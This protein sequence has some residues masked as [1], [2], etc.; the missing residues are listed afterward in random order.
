MFKWID[1]L[2]FIVGAMFTGSFSRSAVNYQAGVRTAVSNIVMAIVVMVVLLAI[3]PLFHYTPNCI[4]SAIIISAVIS[5]I[6]VKAAL[7]IWKV[8]KLDFLACLGAFFGVF[9][10]SVEIGLAIAVSSLPS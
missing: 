7:L 3:T 9:F 4:L 5:L 8:D 6:D 1:V 2:D 10:V